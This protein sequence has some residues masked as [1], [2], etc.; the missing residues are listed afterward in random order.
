MNLN[1]K[2]TV[3][4]FYREPRSTGVS[5]EGIFRT[6][7]EDLAGRAMIRNA[8]CDPKLSRL[9]NT[10]NAS[11][12]ASDINHITGDV[13]FLAMGLRGRKNILTIHDFGYYENPVHSR[14][15]HLFYHTFW[16]ALP[17]R[18]ISVVTVVSQFTKEKLIRYF[19]YPESQI[20]VIPD[21][22]KPVFRYT[23]KDQLADK[24]VILM[25]GS[26][27]HKN[28]DGLIEATRNIGVHLDIVGWPAPDE[29]EKLKTYGI[30]HTISNK[31][32]DEEV[33]QRYAQ[34]DVLY[35]ASHYEGFGMPIIEAQAV[36]R[37][38]IT[39]NI[40]AMREVGEGSALLVDPTNPTD[41]RDAIL[42]ITGDRALYGATVNRGLRNAARFD[43][44]VVSEQYLNLYMELHNQPAR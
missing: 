40:G 43:H 37:P 4:H 23:Y 6:V 8:Y 19:R 15:K 7:K 3:T 30:S 32:S 26:G 18:H 9:R 16:F 17:L 27:K 35:I 10:L 22:V 1:K 20:R 25:L 33:F 13:N 39:S 11:N 34:C 12:F 28:L 36:G 14:L 44:K 21:P 5:I 2:P 41:I 29:L 24:P 31:L 38:V 42:R